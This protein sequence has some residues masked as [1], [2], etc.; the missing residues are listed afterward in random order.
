MLVNGWDRCHAFKDST[1]RAKDSRDGTC[2]H[3]VRPNAACMCAQEHASRHSARVREIESQKE[4]RGT[5]R[6]PVCATPSMVASRQRSPL[7]WVLLTCTQH[8][9]NDV[10]MMRG[11]H[12]LIRSR[13]YRLRTYKNSFVGHELVDLLLEKGEVRTREAARQLGRRLLEAGVI[14]H[15]MNEQDFRD[16]VGGKQSKHYNPCTLWDSAHTPRT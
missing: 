9:I 4:S 13:E 8:H 16:E 7:A 1:Q 2:A 12:K 6:T 5:A 10:Q 11:K 3:I 15:V 14:H